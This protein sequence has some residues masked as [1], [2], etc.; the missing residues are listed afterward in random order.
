MKSM[1]R[2]SAPAKV[3]LLG[4]HFVVYGEP[5]IVLAIDMRATATAEKR[6]DGKIL[7]ES[8]GIGASGFF[9]DDKF[10]PKIG[11]E[12]AERKLEPLYIIVKEIREHADFNE[13]ISLRI[14][15]SIPIASGLGSS[16]A[17][18]VASAAAT[19]SLLNLD[20]SEDNI[21]KLAFDAE[22]II[23]GN[24]SGV[25]P[26]ISTYG[27]VLWYCRS[28][29]IRRLKVKADLP[30]VI[31]NTGKERSTG[32]LVAGVDALLKRYPRIIGRIIKAG[33]EIVKR[34]LY[35]LKKGD[36][37]MLGELMNIDHELLCSI[38]VSC[39]ELDDLVYAAREAGA[40]GAKLTGA[41]GGGCMIALT[42]PERI[43][44]VADAISEAGG[45]VLI[46]R[47]TDDGVIIER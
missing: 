1:A 7:I 2:A 5:A 30:L 14:E 36:L 15:S 46:T 20:T 37:K 4:E 6:T 21:F 13:G 28:K 8:R 29:P 25:D 12:E 27:G 31:G 18:S 11:G 3:I 23:H 35:A 43:M 17:V 39:R 16:A 38:G 47:K 42:P 19:C 32:E 40:Y 44:D 34:S 45:E 26:A 10:F 33:G 24:P 9:V 41:G 22:K